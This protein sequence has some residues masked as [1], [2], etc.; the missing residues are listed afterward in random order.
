MGRPLGYVMSV[1]GLLSCAC[2]ASTEK[3]GKL[4]DAQELPKAFAKAV[5]GSLARCC[6]HQSYEIDLAQCERTLE[7]DLAQELAEYDGL[8]VR[9]DAEAADLCIA[10]YANAACLEQPSENYDVKRNCSVMFKGLID[11]RGTCRDTDEC[12]VDGGRSAQ[13]LDGTCKLDS[14]PAPRGAVGAACGSTCKTSRGDGDACEPAWAGFND[15]APDPSLPA[16]FTSDALHCAGTAGERKCQPLVV[17]GGSCAGSSQGCAAGTFCDPE[18]LGCK[19][20]TS[21]GP[22][23]PEVDACTADALCDLEAGSCVLVGGADGSGCQGDADC[24]NGYCNPSSVC[25]QPFS[26]SFCSQPALN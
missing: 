15:P 7:A 18:T 3:Q 4:S 11:P 20:Q 22:C 6:G 14:E 19:A 23:G 25:Q 2:G 9:F 17:E 12:R 8:Q 5:C 24:R 13:C 10:D 21:S 16:C 26:A 1:L